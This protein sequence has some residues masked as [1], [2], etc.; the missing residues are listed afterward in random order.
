MG[1][2]RCRKARKEREGRREGG[3]EK[4][5][6]VRKEWRWRKS[7]GKG[8]CRKARK[9]REERREGEKKWVRGMF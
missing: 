4:K 3:E 2:G 5:G 9:E 6:E 1:K 8:R 7:M